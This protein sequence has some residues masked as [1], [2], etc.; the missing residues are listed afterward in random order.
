M[1]SDFFPIKNR[2]KQLGGSEFLVLALSGRQEAHQSESL[3]PLK[4]PQELDQGLGCR[5]HEG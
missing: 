1:T 3:D 2:H 4:G 5:F